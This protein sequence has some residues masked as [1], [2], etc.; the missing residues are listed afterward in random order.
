MYLEVKVVIYFCVLILR[1]YTWVIKYNE[2]HATVNYVLI[3]QQS[4]LCTN[5]VH[6]REKQLHGRRTE[7]FGFARIQY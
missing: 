2:V 5:I 7:Y 6:E 4:V 1:C 3:L